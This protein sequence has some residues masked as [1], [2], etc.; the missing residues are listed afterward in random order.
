[1]ALAI[2]LGAVV[3]CASSLQQ[4]D[5]FFEARSYRDAVAAYEKAL[6]SGLTGTHLERALFRLALVYALPE[7][8]LHDERRSR[9]FLEELVGRVEAGPYRSQAAR[10]LELEELETRLS[11]EAESRRRQITE[12]EEEAVAFAWRADHDKATIDELRHSLERLGGELAECREKLEK[13]K[14][15]D[16]GESL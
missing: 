10:I 2:V 11:G 4:G 6:S 3:G 9:D 1:M 14:A 8:P 5:R 16:M 12:L 15:I 7:S 13:L